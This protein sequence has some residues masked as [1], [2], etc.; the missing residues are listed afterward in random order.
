MNPVVAASILGGLLAVDYRSSLGLMVSQPI[1]G[2]LL[3]GLVLGAPAEGMLAGGLIQMIF[4][5]HVPVRGEQKPD[6]PT[7]GVTAAALYILVGRAVGDDPALGGSILFIS[8]FTG[9]LAAV[10]GHYVYRWWERRAT[11][12][13]IAAARS[14]EAGRFRRISVIHLSTVALHFAYAFCVLERAPSTAYTLAR[15]PPSR[16]TLSSSSQ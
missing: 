7:A 8:L 13:A 5:G 6:L 12:L 16:P 3:T 11:A 4:L 14:A 9:M 10:A 15:M 2:G 1:C